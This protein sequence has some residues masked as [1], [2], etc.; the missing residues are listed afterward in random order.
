MVKLWRRPWFSA[1][2]ASRWEHDSSR[3]RKVISPRFGD[4]ELLI[5]RDRGTLVARG[6]VGPARWIKTPRSEEHAKNTLE[7]SPGCYLGTPDDMMTIDMNLIMFEL[8]SMKAAYDGDKEKALL[9]AG[10]AAQRINDMP[11]VNDLV[12]RMMKETEGIL[13]SVQTK[14]LG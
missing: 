13:K 5:H 8:D 7:K 10:E 2:T 1:R 9:A 12:Q 6:F 11:K 3:R 4:R 14:M